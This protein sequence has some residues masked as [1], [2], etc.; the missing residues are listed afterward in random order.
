[1]SKVQRYYSPCGGYDVKMLLIQRHQQLQAR[2]TAFVRSNKKR[3]V[4]LMNKWNQDSD[5]LR[6]F[7]NG[8]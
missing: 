1:M 3:I 5:E 8:S 6:A 7:F 2:D 4:I